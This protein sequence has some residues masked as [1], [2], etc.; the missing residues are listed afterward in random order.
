VFAFVPGGAIAGLFRIGR[1][2]RLIKRA[3]QLQT[4]MVSII[5]TV[6]A[7]TNVFAVLLLLFF[8]FAVIGVELFSGV[9]YGF[10]INQVNNYQTWASSMLTLWRQALGNWRSNLYDTQVSHP[11]CTSNFEQVV[12]ENGVPVSTYSVDDCGSV[13]ASVLYHTAFQ[14]LS[15]FAVLNVVVAI[16]LG[17]FTWCYSLEESE[18][19]TDLRISAQHLKHFRAIWDRFDL[20]STGMIPISD[21]QLFLAVVRWNVPEMFCT[22]IRTQSDA[23]LYRDCSSFGSEIDPKTG[24][25]MNSQEAEKGRRE[26][27]CHKNFN[28]I[29][30]QL[31]DYERS[32][33]LWHQLEMAGCNVWMGCNDNV[34]GFDILKHPLGS[35]DANLHIFTKEVNNGV[36]SVPM[37]TPPGWEGGN[38]PSTTVHQV[39]FTALIN[40]L[41]MVPLQ[42]TPHDMYV[43]FDAKDPFSYFQPGYFGDK[44]PVDGHIRLNTDPESISAPMHLPAFFKRGPEKITED[45]LAGSYTMPTINDA[46]IDSMDDDDGIYSKRT[47]KRVAVVTQ[48]RVFGQH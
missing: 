44:H 45:D 15:T 6:P 26:Q 17:A 5:R 27:V 47:G 10:S 35:T 42:L 48:A 9:R 4:L 11:F 32:A 22:G 21:L 28:T 7:I 30:S 23:M 37:Y 43:C 34:D 14:V 13:M 12:L 46:H 1:V 38:G 16:I 8:I 3:P 41:V 31:G 19:T 24:Q 25:R 29:V 33:E 18:L 2:F 40:I 36:I 39:T 20:Y